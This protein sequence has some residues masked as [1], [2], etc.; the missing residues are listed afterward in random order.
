MQLAAKV[1]RILS[2][3][4]MDRC[5]QQATPIGNAISSL[6]SG[7]GSRSVRDAIPDTEASAATR[8]RDV[9]VRVGHRLKREPNRIAKRRVPNPASPVEWMSGPAARMTGTE[10]R[11]RTD[12][13]VRWFGRCDSDSISTA[14]RHGRGVHRPSR[15]VAPSNRRWFRRVG[16]AP[17]GA[18]QT[19]SCARYARGMSQT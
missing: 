3:K 7:S 18:R 4:E 8:R 16:L 10:A 6:R 1:A 13:L 9:P 5:R 15:V 12:D 11:V 19:D 14:R 17:I 2:R